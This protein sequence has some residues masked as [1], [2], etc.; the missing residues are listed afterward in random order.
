MGEHG[1]LGRSRPDHFSGHGVVDNGL[2]DPFGGRGR[3]H[4]VD[5]ADRLGKAAQ[6]PAPGDRR[7]PGHRLQFCCQTLGH[8]QGVGDRRSTVFAM[9]PETLDRFGDLLFGC[10]AEAGQVA[11]GL[12]LDR[13]FEVVEILNVQLGS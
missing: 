5:I 10:L 12:P 8:W 9:H 7:H 3:D 11:Q 1:G 13:R 4:Q 6:A 2:H